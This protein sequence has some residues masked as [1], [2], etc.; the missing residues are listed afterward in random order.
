MTHAEKVR[1]AERDF[2][3]AALDEA[4][5]PARGS[6]AVTRLLRFY[7]SANKVEALRAATCETCGG[8]GRYPIAYADGH[9][10][11]AATEPC[12]AGCKEGRKL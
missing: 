10:E 2:I 5:A 6:F 4:N 12:H 8:T 1:E 9:V 11:Y 3:E 7:D